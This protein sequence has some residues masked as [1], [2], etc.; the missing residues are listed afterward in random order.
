MTTEQFAYWL[1]GF[2][3]IH[4]APPSAEQ[5]EMIKQHLQTCLKKITPDRHEIYVKY[6][7]SNHGASQPGIVPLNITKTC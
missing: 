1:Q 6:E 2:S 4:G 3:E 5:W 7:S